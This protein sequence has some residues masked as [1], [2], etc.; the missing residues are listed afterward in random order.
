VN[1]TS[2]DDTTVSES[3]GTMQRLSGVASAREVDLA[4]LEA[5]GSIGADD[6]WRPD[7]TGP[8]LDHGAVLLWRY[9][10]RLEPM[11]VVRDDAPGTT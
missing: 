7:G 5:E 1:D 10:A 9:G 11:R 2:G 4:L 6:G 8:F 3:G